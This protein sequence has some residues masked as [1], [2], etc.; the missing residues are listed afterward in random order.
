MENQENQPEEQ[1]PEKVNPAEI[2]D[3]EIIEAEVIRPTAGQIEAL[4]AELE[5]LRDENMTLKSE[6]NENKDKYLRLYAD[7]ENFRKRM[8]KERLEMIHSASE[9]LI[10]KLLPVIDDFERALKS[11]LHDNWS[12][13]NLKEGTQLIFSKLH[14]VLEQQGLTSMETVGKE[15]D[16]E[17]HEA[18]TQVPAPSEDMKGKVI[19]EVEKGYLLNDKLIRVAKVVIGN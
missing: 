6:I 17:V 15:F 18:I 19:D 5:T 4:E 7:F 3:N 11:F 10:V 14:R 2:T 16:M 12:V 9:A 8:A 13:D 1:Q